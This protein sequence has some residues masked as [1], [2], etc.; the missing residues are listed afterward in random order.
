M[1]NAD[2]SHPEQLTY[3]GNAWAGS[4]MWSPDGENV[5]FMSNAAGNWNIYIVS[6]GGGKPRQ[7]TK[8]GA[9]E[10]WPSWSHDGKCIY[11]YS[12]RGGQVQIRKMPATG[13]P[14]I[15]VTR[16][17]GF[18]SNESLDGKDFYYV[19]EQG[20]WKVPA[21]GGEEVEV[22]RSYRFAPGKN[23]IYYMKP[24]DLWYG[25]FQLYFLDSKTHRRR[26]IGVLPGPF[27]WNMDIS[28]DGRSIIYS[29]FDREGSELMLLEN[30][31]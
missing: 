20:L 12:N 3:F 8:E 11:Y 25:P 15:Q 30:F 28:P 18:W 21:A 16:N 7:L 5:A 4:L 27:G 31:K 22:E 26:T 6:S 23:G 13:G 19:N 17:G 10:T 24:P 1:C 14:E 9:D 2:A 29:K